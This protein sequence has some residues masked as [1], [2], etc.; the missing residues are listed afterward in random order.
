[1]IGFMF[2][3]SINK[4]GAVSSAP[5]IRSNSNIPPGHPDIGATSGSTAPGGMQ[6]AAQAAIEKAKQSPNDFDAQ[7]AAAEAGGAK[8]FQA[9]TA[10]GADGALTAN[11]GRV[12]NVTARG[13][14]VREA[15]AAAYAAV[16]KIDF[17]DGFC[18]SD[19]GWREVEREERG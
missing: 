13:A 9:G 6:P 4:N 10:Q 12:L 17:P 7:I 11:G 8:V 2:A 15:Q 1:M 16:D 18:R 19:I 5:E 3:N 14:S